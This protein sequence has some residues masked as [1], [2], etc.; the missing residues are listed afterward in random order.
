VVGWLVKMTPFFGGVLLLAACG[1]LAQG[2]VIELDDNSFYNYAKDRDV[3][4]VDF[5]APWCS[6]CK[7]LEPD[8]Q[9]AAVSLGARSI[10]LAKVDC[11]G[12]GKGLC[13]KY[14]IKEWP[15]LKNFN[16]GTYTGD[17]TGGLSAG[18][19][20]GYV[21]TVENSASPQVVSNPYAAPY[22]PMVMQT[23]QCVTRCKISKITNKA[24]CYAKCKAP[25]PGVRKMLPQ[26]VINEKSCAKCRQ[27]QIAGKFMIKTEESFNFNNTAMK[28]NDLLLAAM[29]GRN[30]FVLGEKKPNPFEPQIQSPVKPARGHEEEQLNIT[31]LAKIPGGLQDAIQY[32]T[33]ETREVADSDVPQKILKHNLPLEK[34]FKQAKPVLSRPSLLESSTKPLQS[35]KTKDKLK[36]KDIDDRANIVGA[37]TKEV[38]KTVDLEV[39]KSEKVDNESSLHARVFEVIK[40]GKSSEVKSN[41]SSTDVEMKP[42]NVMMSMV[43]HDVV[44][45]GRMISTRDR[46]IKAVPL[47]P[48]SDRNAVVLLDILTPEEAS[49]IPYV[50]TDKKKTVA[51]KMQPSDVVVSRKHYIHKR[52]HRLLTE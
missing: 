21:N 50:A 46:E 23:Q 5:Y 8:F 16:R 29:D 35:N 1:G 6:D 9:A 47:R 27:P 39:P 24:P 20:A 7:N 3:L 44:T 33:T 40:N 30:A 36:K 31:T 19:I 32:N 26:P 14:G 17:Y 28:R 13:S 41:G 48:K 12:A 37:E 11:F 52:F 45:K 38:Q 25:K 2:A 34:Q 15:T 18:E 51:K 43:Q 22:T 49:K 10:D 4:L 42:G